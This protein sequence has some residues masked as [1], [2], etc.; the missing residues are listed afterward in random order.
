MHQKLVVA[1]GVGALA[2]GA[3]NVSVAQIVAKGKLLDQKEPIAT[4]KIYTSTTT[5]FYNLSIY[6]TVTVA[7]PNSRS[8]RSYTLEWTDDSGVTN[9]AFPIYGQGNVAGSFGNFTG[10]WGAPVPTEVKAGTPITF[11]ITQAGGA[12]RSEHSLYW[13]LEKLE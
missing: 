9:K 4:R 6:G 3:V 10:A 8:Q 2:L 7:D 5:G 13:T 1:I 12:D 11:A